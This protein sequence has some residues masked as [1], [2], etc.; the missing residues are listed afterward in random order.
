MPSR[1]VPLS[2]AIQQLSIL[3]PPAA[4]NGH[5]RTELIWPTRRESRSHEKFPCSSSFLDARG[6]IGC[7]CTSRIHEATRADAEKAGSSESKSAASASHAAIRAT[8]D[9]AWKC[10]KSCDADSAG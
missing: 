6:V 5:H 8:A 1:K 4:P 2:R 7:F 10:A 3:Y 9:P